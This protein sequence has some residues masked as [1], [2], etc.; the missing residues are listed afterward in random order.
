MTAL[1]RIL[2]AAA[3]L[4]LA[5]LAAGLVLP[6]RWEVEERRVVSAS[7]LRI[8]RALSRPAGW[9]SWMPWP[10]SGAELAGPSFG[11]GA[12]FRWDDAT[13]GAGR[14]TITEARPG[15]SVRYRVSVE[16]GSLVVHGHVRLARGEAGGTRLRW[17]ERGSV[18]WNPLL[19]YVAL[20]L[21]DRQRAQL[22]N[23]LDRLEAHLERRS[24]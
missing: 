3:V 15:R 6:G 11:A 14:F 5:L 1:A 19:G 23:V 9:R 2:A 18:G 20:T 17:S 16:E 8:S 21:E 13:Y 4:L 12:T 10:E 24:S 22:R 7:P